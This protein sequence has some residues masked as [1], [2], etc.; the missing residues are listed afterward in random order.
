MG[1]ILSIEDVIQ[2]F[3]DDTGVKTVLQ[4]SLTD[5]DL[6]LAVESQIVRIIQEAL[7]NIRNHANPRTVRVMMRCDKDN[8]HVLSEDDGVGC[9]DRKK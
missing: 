5:V 1:L 6:P 9:V 2:R 8:Y 4:N 7:T 3:K